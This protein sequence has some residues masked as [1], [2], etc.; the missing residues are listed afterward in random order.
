MEY[1]L[2]IDNGGTT[3]KAAVFDLKGNQIASAGRQTR[4]ITPKPGYTE[5]DMEELWKTNCECIRSAVE[6]S[7]IEPRRI[8]GAA[9][10]G[11][12]KGLYP[13]GK[14]GTPACNG[15]ISTDGRAWEYPLRWKETGV[16]QALYP[17]L[18]QNIMACQ[19]VSLLAWLKDHDRAVYDSIQWV[20]SVKDYIRFRLT[21]EAYSEMTD[22][23]GSGLINVRDA[24]FDREILERF[25]IGEAYEKL[26][27]LCRSCDMCGRIT[28]RAARECGLAEGTPVAGG[29]FDIDA[30]AL[31]M[32]VTT[33]EEMC[34]ITGTWSINEFISEKPITDGT[35]AMNSLY[36]I[37]GY[38][39]E[40]ECSATSA[41][42]LEWL[43]R[44]VM[45]GFV[46]PDGQRI[47][48]Y[49]DDLVRSVPPQECNVYFLPFLYGCNTH[50]L[51]KAAFV[52]LTEFHTRAHLARAVYEGVAFS[53]KMH[54]ERLLKA[55]EKPKAIRMGGGAVN[56]EVWVRMFADVL[57]L[58]VETIRVKELGALGSAMAAAVAAGKFRDYR[59]AADEM[60]HIGGTV[61]P[62]PT[63]AETYREKYETYS[64]ICGALDQVW[65]RFRV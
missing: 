53:H 59:E 52:G 49:L 46:P 36:A 27:P 28:P 24:C 17:K 61:G 15:I 19:Q 4:M 39:L 29:M 2:G 45:D 25:G 16:T 54:V 23:S 8:V 26:P 63:A 37:P 43:I 48:D 6:K 21:G 60:V 11:H 34:T 13:W 44:T 1:V 10:C 22:I 14:D 58:P 41:G 5:R 40:E 20:F 33:P 65:D 7:G 35:V 50:P 42:N 55:R 38:Y 57:D 3:T 64:R 47:Y 18:C 12:G 9:V 32:H 62:D 30:C 31:A 51:G 56:S